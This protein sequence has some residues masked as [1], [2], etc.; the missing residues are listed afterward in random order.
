MLSPVL[1]RNYGE[2]RFFQQLRTVLE[3]ETIDAVYIAVAFLTFSGF[4]LIRNSLG[5]ASDSLAHLKMKALQIV[6]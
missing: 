6:V 1:W 5:N 3:N 2:T 4:K